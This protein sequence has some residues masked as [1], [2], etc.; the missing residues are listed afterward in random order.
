MSG[1]MRRRKSFGLFIFEDPKSQ[2]LGCHIIHDR[3]RIRRRKTDKNQ[4]AA[5]DCRMATGVDMNPRRRDSLN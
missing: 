3:R 1:K 5:A 4:K 2:K